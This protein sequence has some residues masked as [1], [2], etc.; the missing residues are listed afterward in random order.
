MS[1]CMRAISS[2]LHC[3][4]PPANSLVVDP[5]TPPAAHGYITIHRE[6][7]LSHIIQHCFCAPASSVI[8]GEGQAKPWA[9]LEPINASRSELHKRITTIHMDSVPNS[10]R[11]SLQKNLEPTLNVARRGFLV[12]SRIVLVDMSNIMHIANNLAVTRIGYGAGL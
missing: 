4:E 1:Y 10:E 7:S 11:Y 5:P 8:W 2:S 9:P 6:S 12:H 3:Y